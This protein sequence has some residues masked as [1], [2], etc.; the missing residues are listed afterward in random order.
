MWFR[1][2]FH[3]ATIFFTAA[4]SKNY[5]AITLSLSYLILTA[6]LTADSIKSS[7]TME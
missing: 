3:F 1:V 7:D 2:E 6:T 4:K 5:A